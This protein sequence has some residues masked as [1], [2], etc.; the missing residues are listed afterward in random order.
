MVRLA[1]IDDDFY[2]YDEVRKKL[3]GRHG[4]RTFRMGEAIR[5]G[6]A[7][8]DRL[9]GEIDLYLPRE[10]ERRERKGKRKRPKGAAR[11]KSRKG[12][13]GKRRR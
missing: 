9:R 5:G 11:K 6:V 1:S 4:G 8:A 10:K 12:S 13:S 3:V 7:R 2:R